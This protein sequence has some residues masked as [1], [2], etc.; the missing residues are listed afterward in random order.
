MS[1]ITTRSTSLLLQFDQGAPGA[2]YY[3]LELKFK[4]ISEEHVAL[5]N[6]YNNLVDQKNK[7]Q[8]AKNE[9]KASNKDA[10]TTCEQLRALRDGLTK[11]LEM[12]KVTHTTLE[13]DHAELASKAAALEARSET[14]L[15]PE[16]S[17]RLYGR[18]YLSY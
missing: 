7:L 2:S 13:L 16:V 9:L 14:A 11:E 12:L 17:R 3:A 1:S 5:E 10:R 8:R 18:R 4:K 15:D 6:R